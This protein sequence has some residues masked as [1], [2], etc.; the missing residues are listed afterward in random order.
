MGISRLVPWVLLPISLA[1][2]DRASAQRL[3][4]TFAPSRAPSTNFAWSVPAADSVSRKDFR[5]LGAIIGAAGLGLAAGLEA[6]AYC[7]NSEN[8]PRD[9][10]GVTVGVG[11]LGA[12]VAGTLGHLIGQA[13][14]RK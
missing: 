10:T 11:L 1:L 12:A 6:R 2:P 5:W 13:I 4:S 3:Y 9:C 14:P 7:G 8:G